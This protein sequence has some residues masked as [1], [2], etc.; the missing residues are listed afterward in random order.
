MR[1]AVVLLSLLVLTTWGFAMIPSINKWERE[2]GY[3]YGKMCNSVFT[4][5]VNT[6]KK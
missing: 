4:G 3:P 2:A 1:T 6:C 5:Y